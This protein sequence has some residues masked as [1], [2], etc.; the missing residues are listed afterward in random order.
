MILLI[1]L[2]AK[3]V[4]EDIK[5]FIE[6]FREEMEDSKKHRPTLG[7]RNWRCVQVLFFFGLIA[8]S[9]NTFTEII[10]VIEKHVGDS[11]ATYLNESLNLANLF[12]VLAIV[13]VISLLSV[14]VSKKQ[15]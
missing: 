3:I 14:L 6:Y 5:K 15:N 2:I 1:W 10:T 13:M 8:I 9:S 4:G 11:Q 7:A 12:L